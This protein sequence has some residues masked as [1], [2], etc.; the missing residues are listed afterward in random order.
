MVAGVGLAIFWQVQIYA[1]EQAALAGLVAREQQQMELARVVFQD[2]VNSMG[3]ALLTEYHQTG[4][5]NPDAIILIE[6]QL[7]IGLSLPQGWCEPT[8]PAQALHSP[9][10]FPLALV[11]ALREPDTHMPQKTPIFSQL[12]LGQFPLKPAQMRAVLNRLP[13]P[14]R[15]AFQPHMA[16]WGI[17]QPG[18]DYLAVDQ[19][20]QRVAFPLTPARLERVNQRMAGLGV[21]LSLAQAGPVFHGLGP[22]PIHQS[23]RRQQLFALLVSVLV[24]GLLGLVGAAIYQL[25]LLQDRRQTLLHSVSHE[26]RTPLAAILQSS[27]M[28]LDA[29]VSGLEKTQAYLRAIHQQGKRLEALIENLLAYARIERR[30]FSIHPTDQKTHVFIQDWLETCRFNDPFWAEHLVLLENGQGSGRFDVSALAQ[31]LDNLITNARK[32]GQPPVELRSY[33]ESDI[34]R[35]E[36]RDAGPGFPA[37]R[38]ERLLEPYVQVGRSEAQGIG[39]GLHLVRLMVEAHGGLVRLRNG[40]GAQVILEMPL[41]G[42]P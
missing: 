39:L 15:A 3:Q 4:Q 32:Y 41:E 25:L 33:V 18:S 16:L 24:L 11:A 28:L 36:I 30:I 19:G 8:Q 40:P 20:G 26:F 21:S 42:A 13:D 14:L 31:V 34:W 12:W 35:L 37:G 17:S 10:G 38:M 2:E 9:G 5:P 23:Y 6:D 7:Q 27:E 22:M 29:R 1:A